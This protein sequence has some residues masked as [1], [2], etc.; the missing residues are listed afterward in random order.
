[1]LKCLQLLHCEY[2]QTIEEIFYKYVKIMIW[3]NKDLLMWL[4][5]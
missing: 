1:M 2:H 5:N 4:M 3:V